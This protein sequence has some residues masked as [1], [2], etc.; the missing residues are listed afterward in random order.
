[1]G[2][3]CICRRE[4]RAYFQFAISISKKLPKASLA[5]ASSPSL[6]ALCSVYGLA[7]QVARPGKG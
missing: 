5:T 1:M 3:R 4:K 6:G 7:A 2:S